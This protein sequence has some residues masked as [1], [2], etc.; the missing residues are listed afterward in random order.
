MKVP[1]DCMLVSGQNVAC[2]ET[3]L[4]GEPDELEKCALT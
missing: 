2:K 1:A 3:A 4:T